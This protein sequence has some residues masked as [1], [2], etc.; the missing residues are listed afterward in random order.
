M[1]YLDS[2]ASTRPSDGVAAFL[3]ET[4]T[5]HSYYANPDSS[6][7]AGMSADKLIEKARA[8][9]AAA[10]GAQPSEI[11]FTSS[12][13][14]SNNLALFGTCELHKRR[15]SK[16]ITSNAE[17]PAVYMPVK[18]LARRGFD[19]VYLPTRGGVINLDDLRAALDESVILVSVMAVNNETGAVYDIKKIAETIETVYKNADFKPYF[20][21]DGV[22]AFGKIDIN[23]NRI[24][25][26][27]F[28]A[29]AHKI[30]GIKGA[31]FLYLRKGV[32][33]MPQIFGGLQERGL[34]SSTLN[35]PA[36]AA[37]GIA[38]EEIN[39][40]GDHAIVSALYDYAAEKLKG[41]CPSVTIN[42]INSGDADANILKYIISLRLPNVR[43]EVMLN[44]LS[45]R[46]I[47]IS[48]G[49]ACSSKNTDGPR[50]SQ[51]VLT[52]HGLDSLSADFTVRVSFSKYNTT[53]EIDAFVSALADGIAKLAVY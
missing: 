9:I 12:G 44:Y 4:L 42:A 38:A 30:H 3:G 32:R 50:H 14:E 24:K 18:E 6:H 36:I 33:I 29:S 46:G 16:I 41:Q 34:R 8:A 53:A 2:A 37:F 23:L 49:A 20:H 39:I 11:I 52:N 26:D 28:S 5:T 13:T 45:S 47:Y 48:A 51:R 10:L 40:K 21:C 17:H 22:Q 35:T 19:V 31:G 27:M 15:G 25:A 7:A 43:S 1:I